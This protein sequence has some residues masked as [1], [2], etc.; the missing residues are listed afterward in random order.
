MAIKQPLECCKR[1]IPTDILQDMSIGRLG[2]IQSYTDFLL[3]CDTPNPV[4]CAHKKCRVFIPPRFV[5]GEI[6]LCWRCNH[7]TCSLCRKLNHPGVC[8]TNTELLELIKTSQ[9]KYCPH[10][11]N[12]VE[13]A[14]GCDHMTCRCGCE[15][16]YKCGAVCKYWISPRLHTQLFSS[17][18]RP[19]RYCLGGS[20]WSQFLNISRTTC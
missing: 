10:C 4:Y 18:R 6:V 7:Q 15:F 11:S 13:K 8:K 19:L 5:G 9:W 2:A 14:E 3:E 12:V 16:C 20:S 17:S 1:R